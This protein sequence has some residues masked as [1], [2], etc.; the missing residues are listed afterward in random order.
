M[1][2]GLYL[3]PLELVGAGVGVAPGLLM[4]FACIEDMNMGVEVEGSS[5]GFGV[6][7]MNVEEDVICD[8]GRYEVDWVTKGSEEGSGLSIL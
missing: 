2:G 7:G 4:V 1:V 3:I 8:G 6:K 5:I